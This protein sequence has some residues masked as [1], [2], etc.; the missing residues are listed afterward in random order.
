MSELKPCPSPWCDDC[1]PEARRV[2][3]E[4]MGLYSIVCVC[5]LSGPPARTKAEAIAAWNEREG[6]EWPVVDLAITTT[7]KHCFSVT[8]E[9]IRWHYTTS[10]G[11]RLHALF[12]VLGV[13]VEEASE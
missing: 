3:Y 6:P 7:G 2:Q 5:G 12:N 13:E 10:D 4:G 9:T 11:E 1:D 8:H